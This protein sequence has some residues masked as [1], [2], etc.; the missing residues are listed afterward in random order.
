MEYTKTRSFV[1]RNIFS[2]LV[3]LL[4]AILSLMP[5]QEFPQVDVQFADKWAHWVMYGFLTL[6]VGLERLLRKADG[7]NSPSCSPISQV[8]SSGCCSLRP[9]HVWLIALLAA[10]YG[11]IMELVQAFLTTTRN[12]DWMDCAANAFGA[13]CGALVLRYLIIASLTRNHKC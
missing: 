12:G 6:V 10:L 4:I 8:K 7:I 9:V 13:L 11:G 5:A 3:L 2:L 1:R